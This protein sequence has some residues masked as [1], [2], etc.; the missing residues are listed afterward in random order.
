MELKMYLTV[1]KQKYFSSQNL[2]LNFNLPKQV[3]GKIIPDFRLKPT[4]KTISFHNFLL[5]WLI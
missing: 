2:G 1:L 5:L 4:S 3:F